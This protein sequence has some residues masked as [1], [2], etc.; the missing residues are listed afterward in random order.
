[1]AGRYAEARARYRSGDALR[2]LLELGAKEVTRVR[3]TSPSGSTDA[4]DVLDEEGAPMLIITAIIINIGGLFII[5]KP[6]GNGSVNLA[7]YI[8]KNYS[9]K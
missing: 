1:M 6:A 4:V 2:A 5:F 7:Y 8:H 9:K 3:L